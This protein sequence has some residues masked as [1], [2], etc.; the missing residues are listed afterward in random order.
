MTNSHNS[1]QIKINENNFLSNLGAIFSNTGKVINELIQNASRANATTISFTTSVENGR[2]CLTILDDG[3]GIADMQKLLSIAESGWS[4]DVDKCNP[5]GMGFLST[6]FA[7]EHIKIQ[8]QHQM[9][10]SNTED[11]LSGESI[12]IQDSLRGNGTLIEMEGISEAL[13]SYLTST[14][15][16]REVDRIGEGYDID[17]VLN[18]VLMF[19]HHSRM[20]LNASSNYIEHKFEYGSIYFDSKNDGL[21]WLAYLQGALISSTN[22][23]TSSNQ[24]NPHHIVHL[25]DDVKARMP[26]RAELLDAETVKQSIRTNVQFLMMQFLQKELKR[27][28]ESFSSN[29]LLW[30]SAVRYAPQVLN[31]VD[32]LTKSEI[33]ESKSYELGLAGYDGVEHSQLR[34]PISRADVESSLLFA[35]P[36]HESEEDTININYLKHLN[37]VLF[38][39]VISLH[40]DHW[41]H[42]CEIREVSELDVTIEL[43][44][45]T[46]TAT[47]NG[48]YSIPIVLCDQYTLKGEYGEVVIETDAVV[49]SGNEFSYGTLVIPEKENLSTALGI[50]GNYDD[51]WGCFCENDKDRDNY[52]LEMLYNKLRASSPEVLIQKVLDEAFMGQGL[53]NT[54]NNLTFTISFSGTDIVVTETK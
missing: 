34:Q 6:L 15:Y 52:L 20:T 21:C 8:S 49:V 18:G 7:C 16:N 31:K 46:S 29:H 11:I 39:N 2:A 25:N 1:V 48:L 5:Y 47:L 28:G 33:G 32:F 53:R 50:Y 38:V 36:E 54:L 10:S 51:E 24:L 35:L 37:N 12:E 41:I 19:K 4:S 17:V 40:A 45:P 13:F 42:K 23:V 14:N 27:L 22:T 9:L 3:S 43:L 26:D 30:R 44:N